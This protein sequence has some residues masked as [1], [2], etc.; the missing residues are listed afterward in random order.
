MEEVTKMPLF[1][2]LILMSYPDS[3]APPHPVASQGEK[4]GEDITF[5]NTMAFAPACVLSLE[6][7]P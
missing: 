2:L 3:P 6:G 4:D 1:C 7:F 5:L